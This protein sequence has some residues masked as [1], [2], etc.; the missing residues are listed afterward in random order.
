M[1][2]RTFEKYILLFIL[3]FLLCA[4]CLAQNEKVSRSQVRPP[5]LIDTTHLGLEEF[6][7]GA[8]P[9][10]EQL[11]FTATTLMDKEGGTIPAMER[12]CSMAIAVLERKEEVGAEVELTKLYLLLGLARW[13]QSKFGQAV[14]SYT[15]AEQLSIKIGSDKFLGEAYAQLSSLEFER[16]HYKSSFEYC[17]KGLPLWRKPLSFTQ[18]GFN[19]LALL[20]NSVGDY[21]T[22]LE[23]CREAQRILRARGEIPGHIYDLM[24]V[25]FYATKQYD[26][27][28]FYYQY[29]NNHPGESLSETT[30]TQIESQT[31][32]ANSRIAEIYIARQ[33]FDSAIL[34]LNVALTHFERITDGNQIM[35]TLVR[36][37]RA[38]EATRNYP[39]AFQ[40]ARKL[41]RMASETGARQHVR[42]AHFMLYKLFDAKHENDSAYQHLQLYTSLKE[43]IDADQTEQKLAFFK[44]EIETE[45]AKAGIARLKEEK[46]LQ[47]FQLNQYSLE[48]YF[49]IVGL[50]FLSGM[51]LILFRNVSLKRESE[52]QKRELAESELKMQTFENART[53]A[54][55]HQ[56]AAE[57]QMQALRAQMSPHFIFNSLNSIN[58]FILRND[59]ENASEYLVKFSK[60]VRLILQNSQVSLITLENELESLELYLELEAL[61][62]EYRFEYKIIVPAGLDVSGLKVPPLIIQPYAE[63]AIWHGLMHKKEKGHLEIELS[64]DNN[65]L[66]FRILD[67][68]IGRKKSASLNTVSSSIK[69][70]LGSKITANRIEMLQGSV[71]NELG[72]T[73]NDLVNSEGNAMGTEVVIRIP[74]N[75]D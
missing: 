10:K 47:E 60:L 41:L 18:N 59:S 49:L 27:A 65:Y 61:R 46:Q 72:V 1:N 31:I 2:K 12:Y 56:Q 15:K 36:L 69:K 75:Y 68:G 45:K 13:G 29:I 26:S 48:K 16:G 38:Y 57:L 9:D 67:D 43:I 34:Y 6:E 37:C 5:T 42:D 63:N 4:V 50:V 30:S 25:N 3:H 7:S 51:G 62:C 66:F 55:F 23:Y 22:S 32:W 8:N 39:A 71:G 33:K 54:E 28:I 70:S 11:C 19:A 14:E 64:E 17:I 58:R 20:Y 24:G 73:I 21:K 52:K 53:K 74:I 40:S 35:W 44:S